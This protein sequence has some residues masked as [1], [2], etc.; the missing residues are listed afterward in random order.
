MNSKER[1]ERAERV[2][3]ILNSKPP[4]IED[5]MNEN[6]N[7][8]VIVKTFDRSESVLSYTFKSLFSL[9]TTS[10]LIY[11]SQGSKFWTFICGSTFF[12]IIGVKMLY[13]TKTRETVFKDSESLVTWAKSIEFSRDKDKGGNNG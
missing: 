2:A 12:L 8:E 1:E 10:F 5:F 13:Y 4:T 7:N 3:S 6:K 11:L 9:G